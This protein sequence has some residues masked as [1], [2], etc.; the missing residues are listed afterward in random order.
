MVGELH[1]V[2]EHQ[3]KQC[4]HSYK[5]VTYHHMKLKPLFP[6]AMYRWVESQDLLTSV[7]TLTDWLVFLLTFLCGY[8]NFKNQL[9][10]WYLF[11]TSCA[12]DSE[13]VEFIWLKFFLKKKNVYILPH[14]VHKFLVK[15]HQNRFRRFVIKW[16]GRQ[17]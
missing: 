15:L 5:R 8:W 11:V 7:Q 1:M 14:S 12:V 6:G 16:T 2:V 10:N 13:R 17:S 4:L 3:V 9:E